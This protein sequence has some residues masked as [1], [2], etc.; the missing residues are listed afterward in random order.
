M[1]EKLISPQEYIRLRP[2]MHIPLF[3]TRMLSQWLLAEFTDLHLAGRTNKIQVEC[4][5]ESLTIRSFGGGFAFSIL[6]S[7]PAPPVPGIGERQ[8]RFFKTIR[9]CLLR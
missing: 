8:E 2:H 1:S 5:R 6:R 4:S 3:P 9:G 7:L